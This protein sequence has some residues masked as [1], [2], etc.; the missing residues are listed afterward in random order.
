MAAKTTES[1]TVLKSAFKSPNLGDATAAATKV[2]VKVLTKVG[3]WK[4]VIELN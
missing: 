2:K 4:M 1:P 3:T